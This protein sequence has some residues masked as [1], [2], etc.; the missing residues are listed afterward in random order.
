M[1]AIRVQVERT[2][3]DGGQ[4]IG[5]TAP[6]VARARASRT[7]SSRFESTGTPQMS[8]WRFLDPRVRC[9]GG[10][11]RRPRSN[12]RRLPPCARARAGPSRFRRDPLHRRR[13]RSSSPR[14]VLASEA[15]I[16]TSSPEP[17]SV[18]PGWTSPGRSPLRAS[19]AAPRFSVNGQRSRPRPAKATM[20]TRLPASAPSEGLEQAFGRLDRHAE[21]VGHGVLG[22]HAPARIHEE[23]NVVP[24][25]KRRPRPSSPPRLGQRQNEEADR[26]HPAHCSVATQPAPLPREAQ[27][28]PPGASARPMRSA[29]GGQE[30]K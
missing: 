19:K 20:A 10:P 14:T 1:G 25:G 30:P 3:A 21:T 22:R 9:G 2:E 23:D 24:R 7:R 4:S 6:L 5:T 27:S 18:P 29:A 26:R 12:G 11:G 16:A 17:R 28:P 8:K 13:G 15:S